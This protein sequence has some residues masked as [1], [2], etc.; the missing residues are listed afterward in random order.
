M[1][2]SGSDSGERRFGIGV[3][4]LVRMLGYRMK[5]RMLNISLD[6][7]KKKKLGTNELYSIRH[8]FDLIGWDIWICILGRA[9]GF[10]FF[11]FWVFQTSFWVESEA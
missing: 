2:E 6:R 9:M 3:G 5:G 4:V 8:R 7:R 1:S 11:L 10:G